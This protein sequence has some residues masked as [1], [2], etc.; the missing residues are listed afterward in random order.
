MNR[1]SVILVVFNQLHLTRACLASLRST[2]IPFEL[3]VVDNGSTDGTEEFF[4]SFP[5][6][7]PL[8][9]HRQ[10]SN[11]G[12]IQALNLG[13]RL[14]EGE[15]VCFIHNDTEMLDPRW[16]E[17]LIAACEGEAVGLV[18]LYG[19]KRLRRDG[20]YVGRT[21]VHSLDEAPTLTTS[22]TEVAVVDG[23]CLF[24]RRTLLEKLGGFDEAYGFFH[25]YDRDLSFQVRQAGYRCLVVNARYR[26]HGGGTRLS[27]AAQAYLREDLT[28]REAAL[29]RFAEK[30][31]HM[32]PSDVR[33]PRERLKEWIQAKVWRNG[34]AS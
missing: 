21:I 25:G 27:E 8:R 19:A 13:W 31:K 7:F 29:A 2:T 1:V 14:A 30:W 3:V 17:K 11:R 26:H 4:R 34:G 10:P 6:P 33:P 12:L 22:T 18:G 9:H 32:L 16:L 5:E 15:F 28:G 20:R 24:L 23:A